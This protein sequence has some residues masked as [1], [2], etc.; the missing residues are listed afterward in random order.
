[1]KIGNEGQGLIQTL[2]ALGVTA[3]VIA[4]MATA[5]VNMQKS[6]KLLSQKLEVMDLKNQL[7]T[8][9]LNPDNCTCQLNPAVNTGNAAN[10]VFNSTQNNASM[11]LKELKAACLPTSQVLVQESAPLL[12]TQTNLKIQSVRMTDIQPTGNTEE[13]IGN[14]EIQYQLDSLAG[15]LAPLKFRQKFYG[16]PASPPQAK[17]VLSCRSDSPISVASGSSVI[18]TNNAGNVTI[19]LATYGFDALGVDPHILVSERDSNFDA[20]DGNTMDASYCGFV[21]NSKLVF[22]VTCWASPN[23][24]SGTVRSSFDWMA[25]Q[26]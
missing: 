7:Q 18:G 15:P 17:T 13:Y 10:L 23:N 11:N 12:C 8:T 22:T 4:T 19:D 6:N 5:T 20:V 14:I 24:S 16:N 2:I 3:I 9:F 25:I 1:M 26:K 21:K